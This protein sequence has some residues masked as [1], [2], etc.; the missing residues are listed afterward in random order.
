MRPGFRR[1]IRRWLTGPR[2]AFVESRVS[3]EN[4]HPDSDGDSNVEVL[5]LASVVGWRGAGVYWETF[6]AEQ[7]LMLAIHPNISVVAEP[8]DAVKFRI[9][10]DLER[11]LEPRSNHRPESV[12]SVNT[13]DH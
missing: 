2:T 6:E 9:S 7:G 13:S 4:E 12:L 5:S 3:G 11:R 8:A 10:T 1:P